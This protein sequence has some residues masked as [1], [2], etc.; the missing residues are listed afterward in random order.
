M[1]TELIQYNHVANLMVI[2]TFEAAGKSIPEA[3]RLFSHILNAQS[4]WLC[5]I[6]GMETNL[7]T[8]QLQN[9]ASFAFMQNESTSALLALL[10]EGD[11]TQPLQYTTSKGQAFTNTVSDII[12]HTINHSTYHRGQIAMLFRQH[13]VQPPVTDYILYK[14]EGKL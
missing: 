11:L 3:E 6:K 9:P 5:R 12:F 1:L 4:I 10:G 14:R 7:D 2:D 8:F 13:E